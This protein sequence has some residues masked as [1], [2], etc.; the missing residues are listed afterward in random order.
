MPAVVRRVEYKAAVNKVLPS[1]QSVIQSTADLVFE[2][3]GLQKAHHVREG[4]SGDFAE[5]NDHER[6]AD[7]LLESL[8]KRWRLDD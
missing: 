7:S 6:I 5:L 2:S 1:V 4:R 8:E 3:I